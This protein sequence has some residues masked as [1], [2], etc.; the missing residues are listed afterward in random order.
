MSRCCWG[1]I[2]SF[3]STRSL[4]R[5]TCTGVGGGHYGS[6]MGWKG[7]TVSLGPA[8]RTLSV[9]S[10]SISISFP[11][12][13]CT[14]TGMGNGVGRRLTWPRPP[15]ARHGTRPPRHPIITPATPHLHFD[16]H[17]ASVPGAPEAEVRASHAHPAA[18]HFLLD[19]RRE[20]RWE[21]ESQARTHGIGR[22]SANQSSA[23]PL[24]NVPLG[25][26]RGGGRTGRFGG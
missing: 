20:A 21:L 17:R 12:S 5:S 10:M 25:P 14:E 22:R 7:P 3:S 26:R 16:Q 19:A 6:I 23:P 15:P 8:G 2:P 1:G 24:W 4:M 13:V 18:H 11:V 9:G